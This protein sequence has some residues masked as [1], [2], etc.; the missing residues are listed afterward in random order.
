MNVFDKNRKRVKYCPCGKRNNDGKFVPFEGFDRFGF[1]H[2]CNKPFPKKEGTI[3]EPGFYQKF[4]NPIPSSFVDIKIFKKSLN[5]LEENKFHQFLNHH[6]G[7]E[8]TKQVF[9]SYKIGTSN[10]WPGATIFWQI[11]LNNKIR[12]GK[13][14]LYNPKT[15]KRIKNCND[16]AHS[17][18]LRNNMIQDFNLDQC[19]FGLHLLR[20][21]NQQQINCCNRNFVAIVESEKTACIMS[22]LAPSLTWMAC[23]GL[24]SLNYNK[25]RPLSGNKIILFPDLAKNTTNSPYRIW[26]KNAKEFRK[27][28]IDISVSDL[29][30]RKANEK[31]RME[32]WDLADFL[33]F[34]NNLIP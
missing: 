6:F 9:E 26:S 33:L 13:V 2:A 5:H 17:I 4:K 15:G 11:D 23:G 12:S 16:W 34:D 1:C 21:K 3:I 24:S 8:K 29:L 31:Q 27:R 7:I 25:V 32:K 30:E 19:L 14:I 20:N 10:R 28:G 18:L 22:L